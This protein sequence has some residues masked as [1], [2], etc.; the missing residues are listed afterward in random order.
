MKENISNGNKI[1][2]TNTPRMILVVEDDEG[3]SRL[4][5][6][7]L[8]REGFQT[9]SAINGTEAVAIV[10]N[11][12]NIVMLL[13]YRLPDMSGKQVIETLAERKCRVPFIIMTGYGDVKIAVEMMK[14]GARDY[15]VKDSEFLDVLPSIVNRFIEQLEIEKRLAETESKLKKT[16]EKYYNLIEFANAGIIVTEHGKITHVNMEAEKI[17]GYSKK[18]LIGQSPS[19]MTLDKYKDRHR[20]MLDEMMKTGSAKKATFEEEGIRKDGSLI[21]IEISFSLTHAGGSAII[22]V[23]RDISEKKRAEQEIRESKEFLEKIIQGSKDGM[24][25]KM[26]SLSVMRRVL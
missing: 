15:L 7:T 25:V 20:K 24:V 22:A 10:V 16:E 4:I 23:I 2:K 5:Q 26:G 19:I 18:A 17:Y 14:L 6:K 9:E 8:Q 12:Q 1:K 21:P 13:D 3:L 11:N